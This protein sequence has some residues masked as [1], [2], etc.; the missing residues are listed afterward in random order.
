MPSGPRSHVFLVCYHEKLWAIG[1]RDG[2]GAPVR[3]VETYDAKTG[4]WE[5][6]SRVWCRY[7]YLYGLYVL[8]SYRLCSSCIPCVHLFYVLFFFFSAGFVLRVNLM[9]LLI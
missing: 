2:S 5:V 9:V 6:G 4:E 3:S 8:V 7:L 1:G